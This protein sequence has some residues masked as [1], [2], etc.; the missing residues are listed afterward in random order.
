MTFICPAYAKV[1]LVSVTKNSDAPSQWQFP[2]MNS[3]DKFSHKVS[4]LLYYSVAHGLLK[5]YRERH[6]N[7]GNA[8]CDLIVK[9]QIHAGG[10]GKGFF[11]NGY[12]GQFVLFMIIH[13][14][15]L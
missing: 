14:V 3:V 11:S 15:H 13:F 8:Q 5:E 4:F 9:A 6:E 10:R 12:Q 7:D 1:L 2:G